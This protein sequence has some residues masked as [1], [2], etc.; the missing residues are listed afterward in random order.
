MKLI[1]ICGLALKKA[2]YNLFGIFYLSTIIIFSVSLILVGMGIL[3]GTQTILK[4]GLLYDK[5]ANEHLVV[6]VF[7]DNNQ[8]QNQ[9]S[10]G[11][12]TE[13]YDIQIDNDKFFVNVGVPLYDNLDYAVA[14]T[15]LPRDIIEQFQNQ[16]QFNGTNQSFRIGFLSD[17][18]F[19][20]YISTKPQ[21]VQNSSQIPVLLAEAIGEDKEYFNLQK[22]FIFP[23]IGKPFPYQYQLINQKNQNPS[24]VSTQDT[25]IINSTNQLQPVGIYTGIKA[26]LYDANSIIPLS[27]K[28]LVLDEI[29]NSLNPEAKI[30]LLN[31]SVIQKFDSLEKANYFKK[32]TPLSFDFYSPTQKL[33]FSIDPFVKIV[34]VLSFFVFVILFGLLLFSIKKF[35]NSNSSLMAMLLNL[36]AKKIDLIQLQLV[37]FLIPVLISLPFALIISLIVKVV[38]FEFLNQK[39]FYGFLPNL[40]N[41]YFEPNLWNYATPTSSDIFS[42]LAILATIMTVILLLL[43]FFIKNISITNLLKQDK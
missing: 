4:S 42:I 20:N 7:G 15:N 6:Q 24:Q 29:Q 43:L 16:Q 38:V 35:V 1:D 10:D 34:S 25:R 27:K 23:T 30:S 33:D 41:V 19:D 11:L 26:P 18:I 13:V 2:K 3:S 39:F 21:I 28:K 37:Y 31:R 22:K 40:N 32:T 17:E 9:S 5:L 14:K 8:P 36:G 12:R